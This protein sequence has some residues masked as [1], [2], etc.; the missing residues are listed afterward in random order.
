MIGKTIAQY[1]IFDRIGA[2]GMGVVYKAEDLKLHRT[3]ALKFLPDESAGD[4]QART[5]FFEE[6]RAA[7]ALDHPNIGTIYEVNEADGLV[8]I[9]MAYIPGKSLKARILSGP[10]E[11]PEAVEIARQVAEGLQHA[12]DRGIIHR[13]IKPGNIM[14]TEDGR[15][16][17]LDFGLAKIERSADQTRTMTVMG[18]VA[19]MSPEQVLA[20]NV[21]SRTDIWSLGAVLYEMLAGKPPFPARSIQAMMSAILHE[22]PESLASAREG[23]PPEPDRVINRML[24]KKAD[25]RYARA[26]DVAAALTALLSTKSSSSAEG[27]AFPSIAVLPFLNMSADPENEYFS[28]GLAEEII[29]GLS[30]LR[31]LRVVARTSAFAFKGKEQ[32]I[33][34]IGRKLNVSTIL[35]G[36][37]RKSGNRLRITAQL[38]NVADG[39]H[40]WSEQFDR[41]MKDVFA[42]Q[43][44]ISLEITKK[45]NVSLQRGERSPAVPRIEN[46]EAYHLY[47]R[48][49]FLVYKWTQGSLFKAI[50]CFEQVLVD[51]P[52]FAP[53]IAGIAESYFFLGFLNLVPPRESFPKA[54]EMAQKAIDRDPSLAFAHTILGLTRLHFE[55]D[56]PGAEKDLKQALALNAQDGLAHAGYGTYLLVMGRLEEAVIEFSRELKINPL[57]SST[58]FNI[59][60]S[61]MRAGRL[62][63]AIARMKILSE[64]EEDHPYNQWILGQALFLRGERKTGIERMRRA[65]DQSKRNPMILS[66]LGW[67]LA[68]DGQT[69]EAEEIIA[70][71]KRRS[72][73]EQI[74]PYLI[75]KIQAGLNQADQAFAWLE[76]SYRQHDP[77]LAFI[78]TDETLV[79]LRAD[80]RFDD[81]L[82]R[83][84]LD[85]NV[86]PGTD[87][88]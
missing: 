68:M 26:G 53:A 13:D 61:L 48:G 73:E 56:W 62:D 67:A 15:A 60:V 42:I 87:P 24:A 75:A 47:L 44:E 4:P 43:D 82:V 39:F 77:S 6:A 9:A 2:G 36:S 78:L 12:H 31:H 30:R 63:Q 76:Q 45:L 29:N 22:R 58:A 84:K 17:I 64:G 3:V 28:E 18:T 69:T 72:D 38:I 88:G 16:K 37:V 25:E 57:A 83:L 14:L 1:R 10:L 65:V 66:G 19:Y 52:N 51:A 33:R 85:P 41:E 21:D 27:E 54:G 23:I 46:L 20:E 50:D 7:A 70:E 59:G 81:L 55:W 11:I 34:E 86:K 32:D 71:L 74:R 40:F 35:E 5:R 8:Y 80:P 79:H 49:R